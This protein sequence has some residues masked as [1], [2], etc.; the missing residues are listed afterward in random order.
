MPARLPIP[1][2]TRQR[3][4]PLWLG[5]QRL[6]RRRAMPSLQA[7]ELW[8]T[9][10]DAHDGSTEAALGELVGVLLEAGLLARERSW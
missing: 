4:E 7:A 10:L 8:A 1:P 5:L 9:F 2:E 3:R 6:R